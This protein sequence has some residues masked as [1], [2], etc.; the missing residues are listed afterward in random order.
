MMQ[1]GLKTMAVACIAP[2]LLSSSQPPAASAHDL[3]LQRT[4]AGQEGLQEGL[5]R[6]KSDQ[7]YVLASEEGLPPLLLLLILC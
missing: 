1:Q 7:M 2:L 5:L 6:G 3:S 4:T